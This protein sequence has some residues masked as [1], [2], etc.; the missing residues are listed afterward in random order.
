MS[1]H[2]FLDVSED[3]LEDDG[4]YKISGSESSLDNVD[5][6]ATAENPAHTA[7]MGNVEIDIDE[8]DSG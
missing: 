3:E 2:L 7:E 1:P 6:L 8:G 5:I 4:D